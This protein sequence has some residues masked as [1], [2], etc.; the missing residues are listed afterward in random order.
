MIDGDVFSEGEGE[1]TDCGV[2][3]EGYCTVIKRLI[4]M[5]C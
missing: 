3:I 1:G 4:N 2:S 5:P